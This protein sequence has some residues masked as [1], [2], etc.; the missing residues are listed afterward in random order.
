ML[1]LIF[2]IFS[3]IVLLLGV[4]LAVAVGVSVGIKE[5]LKGLTIEQKTISNPKE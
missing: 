3:F 4:A 5:G 2:H 1:E